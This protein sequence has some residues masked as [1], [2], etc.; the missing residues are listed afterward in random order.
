ML[1]D[2]RGGAS[3]GRRPEA[4]RDTGCS[5][6]VNVYVARDGRRSLELGNYAGFLLRVPL[7][8]SNVDELHDDRR[9]CKMRGERCSKFLICLP[10]WLTLK[11]AFELCEAESNRK[12]STGEA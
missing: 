3:S 12:K 11:F 5:E 10:S 4:E 8:P 6:R 7:S 2:E 9:R 1:Q